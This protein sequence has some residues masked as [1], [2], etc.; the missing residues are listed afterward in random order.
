MS[1]SRKALAI[2]SLDDSILA[3]QDAIASLYG[4]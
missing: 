1:L 2:M 4:I 3:K